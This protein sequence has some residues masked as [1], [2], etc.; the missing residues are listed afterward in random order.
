M[1][2]PTFVCVPGAWH[3]PV[4]YDPL[5]SILE[6]EGFECVRVSLP[7]VGCK[8]VT[9][10]FTE[11]VEA[12]RSTFQDLADQ[13]KDIIPVMHS[14][15][16]MCGSQAIEGFAKEERVSKGLKGGVVRSTTPIFHTP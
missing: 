15:S 16:G 13:G 7:S 3:T 11:D 12:I 10:D 4:A 2:N 5:K 6:T 1:N 9:Y 8:P 14:Y